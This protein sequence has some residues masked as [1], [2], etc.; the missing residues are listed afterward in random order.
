MSTVMLEAPRTVHTDRVF[1]TGMALLSAAIVFVGF[2]PT[3]FQRPAGLGALSP[4]LSIHG[5]VF[6]SWIAL[7][8][9][10]TGLIA[11][12]QRAWHRSLGVLGILLATAMIVLGFLAAVDSLNRGAVPLEGLDPRSFFA[13]PVRDLV[14]FTGFVGAAVY[15][16]R[17]AQMH[18]RLM[19]LA[20][21]ALL[22]AAIARAIM[23]T[24]LAKGGPPAFYG[25]QDLLIVAGMVY[26]RVTQGRVHRAWKW[27]L[28]ITIGSQILFLA[29]S[30]TRPWLAFADL[31][32]RG[33]T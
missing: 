28:G 3:F 18:K 26:D 15:F 8:I 17:D 2:G 22:V 33:A 4:L 30:G 31:F 12:N 14:V 20:T 1:Y 25:L 5:I 27:G 24:P 19:L 23:D 29:I 32:L 13:I 16:R 21:F 9:A 11:A 10:Q 6:T 7:L